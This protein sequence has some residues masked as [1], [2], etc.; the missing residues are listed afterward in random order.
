[1]IVSRDTEL[2][3]TRRKNDKTSPRNSKSSIGPSRTDEDAEPRCLISTSKKI[4]AN[5]K[6]AKRSIGPRTVRGKLHSRLNA[7]KHGAFS[8]HRLLP[9]EV[10]KDYAQLSTFVFRDAKPKTAIE[11]MVVDQIVGGIWRLRRVEQAEH[12]YF[13]QVQKGGASSYAQG[14]LRS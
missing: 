12:A 8:N 7:L 4:E 3:E 1:M 9:G 14:S 2:N 10:E 5:R 11:V 13:R 6:N